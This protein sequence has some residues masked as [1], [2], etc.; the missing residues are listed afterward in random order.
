MA[1]YT[2]RHEAYLCS[3]GH[4][5]LVLVN[6]SDLPPNVKCG[7]KTCR[8]QAQHKGFVRAREAMKPTYIAEN[9][10]GEICYL[11]SEH[12]PIPEGYQKR[13]ILPSEIRGWERQI[14]QQMKREREEYESA[15]S[16]IFSNLI[17]RSHKDLKQ[18]MNREGW[19]AEHREIAEYAMSK[20]QE[21]YSRN[22]DA[23]FRVAAHS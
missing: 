10:A 12:E 4:E 9:K 18:Q 2:L 8:R 13:A 16:A 7:R 14:N 11:G 15:E 19:D 1:R 22:F 17:S 6:L 21:R 23:E 3:K 20:S 5:S